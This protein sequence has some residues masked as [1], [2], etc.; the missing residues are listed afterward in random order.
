MQLV[1]GARPGCK[2]GAVRKSWDGVREGVL[3][4]RWS[5]VP[6]GTSRGVYVLHARLE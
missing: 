3:G 6:Y 2:L 5:C 4:R 1:S